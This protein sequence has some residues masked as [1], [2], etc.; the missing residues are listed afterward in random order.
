MQLAVGGQA[1]PQLPQ[2]AA[3]VDKSLH[4][5]PHPVWPVGQFVQVPA[6][7]VWLAAHAIA[8]VPQCSRSVCRFTHAPPQRMVPAAQTHCPEVHC[9]PVAH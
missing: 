4:M 5:V 9:S 7:Q 6:L 2:F 8:Q 3:S 1:L